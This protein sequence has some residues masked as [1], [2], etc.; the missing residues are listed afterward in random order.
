M[1]LY[2]DDFAINKNK[3][4]VEVKLRLKIPCTKQSTSNSMSV[5]HNNRKFLNPTKE[6]QNRLIPSL[7]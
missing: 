6:P 1:Y 2:Y 3:Y 4:K 5:F 7:E